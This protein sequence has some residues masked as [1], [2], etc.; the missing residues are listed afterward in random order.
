M[1]I[2]S[3]WPSKR[4]ISYIRLEKIVFKC[5]TSDKALV[6]ETDHI[7][8]YRQ[9]GEIKVDSSKF[10]YIPASIATFYQAVLQRRIQLLDIAQA[11]RLDL[12]PD[13]GRAF[14]ERFRDPFFGTRC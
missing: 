7:L 6:F 14:Y 9:V 1:K 3:F 4:T 10:F 11:V 8:A 12:T 2:T 5:L 13:T